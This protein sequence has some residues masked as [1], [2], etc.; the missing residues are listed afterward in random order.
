MYVRDKWTAAEKVNTPEWISFSKYIQP[1]P[2][3][4][5][6]QK[7]FYLN[8]YNIY[9]VYL[10]FTYNALLTIL[11]LQCITCNTLLTMHYLQYFTNPSPLPIDVQSYG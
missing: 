9:M 6:W 7:V 2:P 5:F 8:T 4:F 11:Y 10:Y 3:P 1:P